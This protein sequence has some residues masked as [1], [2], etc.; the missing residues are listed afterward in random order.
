MRSPEKLYILVYLRT[1]Q[2]DYKHLGNKKAVKILVE[3]GADV[4]AKDRANNYTPVDLLEKY[5]IIEI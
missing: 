1:V 2:Y 4:N 3:N 5:G